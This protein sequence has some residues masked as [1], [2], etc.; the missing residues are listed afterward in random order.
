MTDSSSIIVSEGVRNGSPMI[1]NGGFKKEEK[2]I[3]DVTLGGGKLDRWPVRRHR[4][5][6]R[7]DASFTMESI[8][9]CLSNK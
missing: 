3:K 7:C 4:I 5:L 6:Q 8:K 9:T 1:A 2:A